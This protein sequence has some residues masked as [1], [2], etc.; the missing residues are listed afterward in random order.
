LVVHLSREELVGVEC[1]RVETSF[2]IT[3]TADAAHSIVRSIRLNDTG[4]VWVIMA[5]DWARAKGQLKC[6]ECLLGRVGP[7]KPGILLE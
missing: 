4:L 7:D 1:N 6:M 3:L 5:K 2:F